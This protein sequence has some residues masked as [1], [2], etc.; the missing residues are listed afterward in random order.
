MLGAKVTVQACDKEPVRVKANALAASLCASCMVIV[1][2]E[3]SESASE[4]LPKASPISSRLVLV[5]VP[6][7][8]DS[9]PVAISFSLR[10]FT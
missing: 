6:Q 3:A 2:V 10:S 1:A 4:P 5:E 7:V 9:S 8:P